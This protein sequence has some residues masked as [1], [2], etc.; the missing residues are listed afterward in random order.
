VLFRRRSSVRPA[1]LILAAITALVAVA[2][3]LVVLFG[4][5][6]AA[7]SERGP[8][9]WTAATL[10]QVAL[11]VRFVRSPAS[12]LGQCRRTARAVGYAVP[13]PRMIPDGL[14]PTPVGGGPCLHYRFHIVGLPCTVFSVWHGWVV[15]SSQIGTGG[16]AFQHLVIQVSPTPTNF[17]H[18]VNG[19]IALWHRAGPVIGG[20]LMLNGWRMHWL[21]V[22]PEHNDGSAFMSHVVLC[23]TTGG[24]TYAVGFHTVTTKLSAAAMDYE[25]VRNLELVRP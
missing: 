12:L 2:V 16:P 13:C 21:F 18:A 14:Q 10:G 11:P 4:G 5:S 22:D 7:P 17:A 15:G 20:S 1:V 25:L 8:L 24:H 3:G 9:H 23:W 6:R 19:P